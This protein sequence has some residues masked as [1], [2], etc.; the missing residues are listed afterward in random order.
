MA[1]LVAATENWLARP[2]SATSSVRIHSS[3]AKSTISHP[4]AWANPS[5]SKA[6]IGLAPLLPERRPAANSVAPTPMLEKTP[7]PVSTT[8]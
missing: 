7:N 8:R 5:V 2:S 1:I 6:V 4:W 3:G